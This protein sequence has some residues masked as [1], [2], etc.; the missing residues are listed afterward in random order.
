MALYPLDF[1]YPIIDYINL[2]IPTK[3]F[4]KIMFVKY[5]LLLLDI[6]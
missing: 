2:N 5:K 1:I 4:N 3:S 6:N